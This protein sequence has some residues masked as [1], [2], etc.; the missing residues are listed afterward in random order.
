M[1]DDKQREIARKGGEAV[2]EDRQHMSEIGRKGGEARGGN[3]DDRR[4]RWWRPAWRC[5]RAACPS[6]PQGWPAL[7]QI[8]LSVLRNAHSPKRGLGQVLTERDPVV[9]LSPGYIL[10]NS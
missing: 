5:A 6:R 7:R 9:T 2:S 1:D 4:R 10:A 3:D 8:V